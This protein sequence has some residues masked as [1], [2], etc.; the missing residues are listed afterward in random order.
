MKNKLTKK[1]KKAICIY[2]AALLILYVVV[3]ILPRVTDI[4]ETTQVLEPGNLKL[5]Y[6]T[7]GYLIKEESVGIAYETGQIEYLTEVGAA[8]KRG[9]PLVA[10]EADKDP[11]D[12]T[13][14]Y[15]DYTE[16]LA[17]YDGLYSDYSAPI[18]GVFSLTID[19]YEDYFIP[20]NMHT[21]KRHT[22]E[23]IGLKPA[24]LERK[25]VIRG[26]PIYKVTWDDYWY[27]L[28]WVEKETAE[29]YTEGKSVILELPE[30]E[31]NAR[32]HSI[33]K[34][35]N[36]DDYRVIFYLNVYYEALAESR[37]EDIS[38]VTSDNEGLLIDNKCIIEKNGQTGV[39]VVNKNG[40]YVFTRIKVIAYDDK[41]SVI[42]DVTFYDE[43]GNQVYTV[44]VYDEV[45]KNP[46]GALEK[47]LQ[48]E[49]KEAEQSDKED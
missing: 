24:E 6:E 4:F 11:G 44:D 8:I 27:V 15:E 39:Y 35:E 49:A 28:C 41:H 26:E 20:E 43:E 38:I 13:P 2:I 40:D 5:S 45:L 31:V 7:K 32:I 19:G 34:E 46:K 25:S 29:T 14:R 1:T 9:H 30:G 33:E 18:S 3:E 12:K 48:Q 17:G 10:V 22:V 47:D 23:H 16:R 36:S 42:E 37:A 21:M